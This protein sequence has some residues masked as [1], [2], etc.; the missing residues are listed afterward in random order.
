MKSSAALLDSMTFSCRARTCE[1]QISQM[2]RSE[3][4]DF[5]PGK[6]YSLQ[7]IV[8]KGGR[9][10]SSSDGKSSSRSV[11]GCQVTCGGTFDGTAALILANSFAQLAGAT[12]EKDDLYVLMV[13]MISTNRMWHWLDS[14]VSLLETIAP[15]MD[16]SCPT[17]SCRE[18]QLSLRVP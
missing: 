11:I 17:S 4:Y 1:K 6:I 3:L 7:G 2:L 16:R 8:S 18:M 10:G 13:I 5:T 12:R 15:T 14:L 9:L